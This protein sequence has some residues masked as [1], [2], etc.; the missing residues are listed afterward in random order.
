MITSKEGLCGEW[1]RG[2][3]SRARAPSERV[4][5]VCE[6]EEKGPVQARSC[7]NGEAANVAHF[8]RG[9]ERKSQAASASGPRS[10]SLGPTEVST[11]CQTWQWVRPFG[12]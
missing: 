12:Q 2:E 8:R 9:G 11:P 3:N 1:R 5:T 10:G 4:L 6:G 7:G